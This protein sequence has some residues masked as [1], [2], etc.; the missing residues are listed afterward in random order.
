VRRSKYD[1]CADILQATLKGA[2]K[3]R[4]VYASNL[5]FNVLNTYL[6]GLLEKG[7][8][9]VTDDGYY[10]T[11][12]KGAQFLKEYNDLITLFNDDGRV[13]NKFLVHT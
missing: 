9:E 5:N 1:I 11:T 7:F 4:V 12:S 6:P 10:L 3:T 2:K 8:L 13:T